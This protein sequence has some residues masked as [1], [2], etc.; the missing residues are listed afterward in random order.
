MRAN[1]PKTKL[2]INR[3]KNRFLVTAKLSADLHQQLRA[4]CVKSGQNIN[5]ALRHILTTFLTNHG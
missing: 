2:E 5:Q 3:L 1:K 4:Y